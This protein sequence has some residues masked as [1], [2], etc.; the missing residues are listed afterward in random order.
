MISDAI[1]KAYQEK[2]L[3]KWDTL[4]FAI[5]LHGTIIKKYT[6]NSIEA[7]N[8][9]ETVL[10]A[11][12]SLSDV[13]LILYTSTSEENLKPFYKW[14]SDRVI[15]FKYLNENPECISNKTGDFSKKFYFN[16]LIDDRAGFDPELGWDDILRSLNTASI[17]YLCP[18]IETCQRGFRYSGNSLLCDTCDKNEYIFCEKS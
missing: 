1:I 11:L 5:D 7:Y 8:G 3:R 9:A 15:T 17:M 16:V 10:K 6:G 13:V 12:T 18:H 14:C 2:Y 4:Y